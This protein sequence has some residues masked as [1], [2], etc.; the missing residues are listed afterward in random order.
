[1]MDSALR[2][3]A[4]VALS[5]PAPPEIRL[6]TVF[7]C[8]KHLNFTS[9]AVARIRLLMVVH[10]DREAVPC[11]RWV[12]QFYPQILIGFDDGQMFPMGRPK[13]REKL[14]RNR[15]QWWGQRASVYRWEQRR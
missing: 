13:A 9:S 1:M 14:L 12:K 2:E 6:G 10:Q 4:D 5:V 8:D 11:G 7:R 15:R 3:I